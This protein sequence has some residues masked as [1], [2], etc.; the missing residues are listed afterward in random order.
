MESL[1]EQKKELQKLS[2][3]TEVR[4]FPT[5]EDIKDDAPAPQ[6]LSAP[7][8]LL[9]IV[10]LV[11]LIIKHVMNF[12]LLYELLTMKLFVF[13]W[14]CLLNF[15]LVIVSMIL[16]VHPTVGKIL[17]TF[18]RENLSVAVHTAFVRLVVKKAFNDSFDGKFI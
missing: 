17:L 18:L 13:K 16:L 10:E 11:I 14:F 5:E 7:S 15:I 12:I 9:G 2:E 6:D 4:I 1:E 8:F 3:A